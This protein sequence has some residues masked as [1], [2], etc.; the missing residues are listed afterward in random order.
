MLSCSKPFGY[1]DLWYNDDGSGRQRWIFKKVTIDTYNIMV[2]D[3]TNEGVLPQMVGL[4][5]T[6][7][8]IILEG[9]NG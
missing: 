1:V 8:T 2:Y 6:L 5:C 9:K 3:G 4:S 7:R